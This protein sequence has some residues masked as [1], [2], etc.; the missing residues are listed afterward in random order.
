M[1]LLFSIRKY[2]NFSPHL[3]NSPIL[4]NFEF[5]FHQRKKI[6]KSKGS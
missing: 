5:I 6:E 3:L 1:K 2:G 4:I